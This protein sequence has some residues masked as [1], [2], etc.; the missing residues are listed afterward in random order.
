MFTSMILNGG[1][2]EEAK[3]DGR[4]GNRLRVY[5]E[6]MLTNVMVTVGMWA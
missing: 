3:G 2:K 5:A 4:G 6:I 1:T